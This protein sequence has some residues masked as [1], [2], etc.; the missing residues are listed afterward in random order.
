MPSVQTHPRTLPFCPSAPTSAGLQS[1]A[2]GDSAPPAESRAHP[3]WVLASTS[4][5]TPPT[6]RSCP[7]F[8]PDARPAPT[9]RPGPGPGSRPPAVALT[10]PSDPAARRQRECS[11][12]LRQLGA[13]LGVRP[14]PPPARAHAGPQRRGQRP[15]ELSQRHAPHGGAQPPGKYARGWGWGLGELCSRASPCMGA[16]GCRG[17]RVRVCQCVQ[18]SE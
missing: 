7:R 5:F 8:G 1:P 4:S 17:A 12:V 10:R 9:P 6:T 3:T 13:A 16:Q 11:D 18:G 2:L 14:G 15:Q